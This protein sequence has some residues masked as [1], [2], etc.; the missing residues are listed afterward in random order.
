[1][2]IILY[3]DL[4]QSDQIKTKNVDTNQKSKDSDDVKKI[5]DL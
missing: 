5:E 3:L 2:L 1:M 4:S